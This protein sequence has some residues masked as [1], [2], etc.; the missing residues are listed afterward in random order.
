MLNLFFLKNCEDKEKLS[1]ANERLKQQITM[2]Y[3]LAVDFTVDQ[4][5]MPHY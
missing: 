4:G 2:V 1:F 3:M 5:I